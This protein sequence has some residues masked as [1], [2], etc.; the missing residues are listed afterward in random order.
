MAGMVVATADAVVAV[1]IRDY[2]CWR[3][4]QVF[5]VRVIWPCTSISLELQ[6]PAI[7]VKIHVFSIDDIHNDGIVKRDGHS[8]V[9]SSFVML[10]NEYPLSGVSI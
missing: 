1:R 2:Y 5:F 7:R 10:L 4:I 6:T 8:L 9:L 3:T